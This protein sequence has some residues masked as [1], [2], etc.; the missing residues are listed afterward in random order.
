MSDQKQKLSVSNRKIHSS[1]SLSEIPVGYRGSGE[2]VWS[3]GEWAGSDKWGRSCT[4]NTCTFI[5]TANKLMTERVLRVRSDT[6]Y[7]IIVN[8]LLLWLVNS[9][10]CITK[11]RYVCSPSL[12]PPV[13]HRPQ[14][15]HE[16]QCWL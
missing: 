2:W 9:M 4:G 10:Y 11:H 1:S 15:S 14:C 12:L 16:R 5:I 8:S 7:T 3:V 13:H 6:Q